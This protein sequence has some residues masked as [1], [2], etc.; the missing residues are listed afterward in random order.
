MGNNIRSS[1]RPK[2][3][4]PSIPMPPLADAMDAVHLSVD[5][6]CLLAGVEALAEMMEEDAT[7]VCGARHRRH[8]DRRGYRWGRTHSEIG[9]HGGKVKVARPRVRDRAGK[10]VSLESWQALRDGNLLLE[11]ALNLM[12]LNVS[13]RKYHRA[14]RLPEGDLAK[15]RGDGTSKSAVSRRFVAL[16]RKKMKA[17]LASDLSE[18][19][20][21][22]IQI[23]GLHVGDHVLMAAI[24]VDGNG[25]KHVLA[26]VEGAPTENTVVVQALIDNLLARG[27][28]PTLPRLFIVDG[29]KALSKAIRN[30][31]GVAAAIQRCQ[32]H[33]GR[34]II[35]RLPLHLHASV[36]K[37]LRQAWDQDDADKAERL[38]RNLARRLEHEEPGVSG[39]ILEGLEEILTVIR[40]GLPHELRR[41]LACTNIV[42]NA[43]GTVR[44]VT[45]NVKRWRH[46]EM[47][48]RW[49]AAGLLEA[50][51]TFRRLKAYRQLPILR[52]MQ[53][54]SRP[55][56]PVQLEKGRDIALLRESH[57]FKLLT[58][59]LPRTIDARASAARGSMNLSGRVSAPQLFGCDQQCERAAKSRGALAQHFRLDHFDNQ[60]SARACSATTVRRRRGRGLARQGRARGLA[61]GIRPLHRV[62]HELGAGAKSKCTSRPAACRGDVVTG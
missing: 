21:L 54:G 14:V 58:T 60:R 6:F 16:S 31:F 48:L 1:S 23:D 8:G 43:L 35:E 51:K 41:S 22:V 47:A 53:K 38:L 12:V 46:A 50:Q 33:K 40:L 49:T 7:T 20:L 56:K 39:S 59:S 25:D 5:R 4:A 29:A 45:R 17:W 62:G 55:L 26:V 61:G 34:N 2:A 52:G 57:N 32:V 9:Y 27:L 19:D 3:L 18:L 37:A 44:Q 36:K 24:G 13:T 42:E 10:E 28:D 15:A 11:W 30:T